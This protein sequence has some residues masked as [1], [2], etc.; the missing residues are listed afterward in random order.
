MKIDNETLTAMSFCFY[1]AFCEEKYLRRSNF[2]CDSETATPPLSTIDLCVYL[3]DI[4]CSCEIIVKICHFC[5][6]F[7]YMLCL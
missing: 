7:S 1:I 6:S 5:V 3:E 2:F 4:I